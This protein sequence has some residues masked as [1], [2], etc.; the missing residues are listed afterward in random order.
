MKLN[1]INRWLEYNKEG[2]IVGAIVGVILYYL[3]LSFIN[4]LLNLPVLWWHRLA[5][6]V[7]ISS[8]IGALI[9]SIYKPRT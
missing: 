7:V 1:E 9:D 8:I 2:M 3:N 5:I 6:L 4:N